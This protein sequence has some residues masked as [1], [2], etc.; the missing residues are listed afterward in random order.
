M[1]RVAVIPA[2]GRGSRLGFELPKPL[3][4]ING[5]PM[6]A[7][8]LQLYAPHAD[9]AIVVVSPAS[10]AGVIEAAGHSGVPVTVAVQERPTGMLDAIL[11]AR[12]E[13]ERLRPRR[14]LISWCDQVAMSPATVAAV[15]QAARA[16]PEP[17]LVLPTCRS[18]SPYVH[19][20][21]DDAGRIVDVLHR[22]EGDAMP[23]AGESDAGVFDLSLHAFTGWLPE[24]AATPAI[25]AR[26]GET[27]FVPF[28]AWAAARGTV[29][30][31]PCREPE[32][33]VGINTPE[34]LARI[35]AHLRARPKR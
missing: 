23:Q 26:T 5:R 10:R 6:I 25:G 1:E 21:R 4:P 3:V 8:V 13:L 24:Y 35:E 16:E 15:V 11:L 29:V 14:V 33:A 31:I 19:L 9:R 22:R 2:A 28:V 12:G 34:E 7:H 18:E 17:A 27:N 30:T 32:E 20:C